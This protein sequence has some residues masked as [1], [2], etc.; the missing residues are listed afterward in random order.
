MRAARG[1]GPDGLAGMAAVRELA[2][3]P[4]AAA[5]ADACPRR[6]CSPPRGVG[7]ALARR[8]EQPRAALR[9][10]PAARQRPGFDAA[11]LAGLAAGHARRAGRMG[12]PAR[13]PGSRSMCAASPARLRAD[14]AG[15]AGGRAGRD[16]APGR[17][18]DAAR[19][20]RPA[21]I[22]RARR[23]SPACSTSCTATGARPG[24]TLGGCRLLGARA[25]GCW[26]AASRPRSPRCSSP[27]P[28][29]GKCWDGR[30]AVR[31]TGDGRR[32]RGPGARRR[33]LAAA[34]SGWRPGRR[35]PLRRP[36]SGQACLRSGAAPAAGR[37]RLGLVDPAR[38]L[39][40]DGALRPARSLVTARRLRPARRGWPAVS[41]L[42]Q[43]DMLF[44]S[45]ERLFIAKLAR[46]ARMAP[47]E[48]GR[49]AGEANGALPTS[50]RTR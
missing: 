13:A 39:V 31:L 36:R 9:A 7:P 19:G 26:S 24:A 45:R 48:L 33:G 15:R 8:S 43:G 16:R 49:S 44:Q 3:L 32:P 6:G 12:A 50:R 4:A 30:F 20:R 22:R 25:T 14:G 40:A 38:P 23:A 46:V 5:A 1:S 29:P 35:Q 21:P 2:G 47:S 37:A 17:A 34:R 10:R 18:A 42:R 27:G 28:A 11:R 41:H